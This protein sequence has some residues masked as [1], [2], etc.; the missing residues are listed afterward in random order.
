MCVC[1]YVR[2]NVKMKG[3]A[4]K[5]TCECTESDP[6]VTASKLHMKI[7]VEPN[8]KRTCTVFPIF[9][10]QR[11]INYRKKEQMAVAILPYVCSFHLGILR[12]SI[13]HDFR[14]CPI[15]LERFRVLLDKITSFHERVSTRIRYFFNCSNETN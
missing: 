3:H 6:R 7:I 9:K 8:V 12:D 1:A 4:C 11:F 10:R 13:R 15:K 5:H 14:R 2:A